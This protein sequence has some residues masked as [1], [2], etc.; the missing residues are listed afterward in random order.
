[1]ERHQLTGREAAEVAVFF[2]FNQ[3]RHGSADKQRL[4]GLINGHQ[5]PGDDARLTGDRLD[6]LPATGGGVY[7]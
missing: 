2:R 5:A 7:A 6:K 3:H 1:M 4:C